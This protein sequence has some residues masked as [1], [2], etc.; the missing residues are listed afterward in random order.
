MVGKRG[1]HEPADEIRGD[2]S[3]DIGSEGR[4]CSCTHEMLAEIGK[5]Q[6][7]S[8]GHAK[9]LRDTEASE[10]HEIGRDCEQG[11]RYR[12]DRE[13]DDDAKLPVDPPTED[14]DGEARYRHANGCRIDRKPHGRG[15]DPVHACQ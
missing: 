4:G 2:V 11:C 7:E 8:P 10:G 9:S 14:G 12:K 13:A 1:G 5:G 15:R 3:G 6:R